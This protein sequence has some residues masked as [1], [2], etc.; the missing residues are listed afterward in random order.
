MLILLK[1]NTRLEA[2]PFVFN[3]IKYTKTFEKNINPLNNYIFYGH[4]QQ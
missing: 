1:G 2:K 3:T 4:N